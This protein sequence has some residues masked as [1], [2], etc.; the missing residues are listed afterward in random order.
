[1]AQMS[2]AEREGTYRA[3]VR[4]AAVDGTVDSA[5]AALLKRL[6]DGLGLDPKLA[7]SIDRESFEE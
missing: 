6:S 2:A 5:E 1:M 7:R 3:A 4:C